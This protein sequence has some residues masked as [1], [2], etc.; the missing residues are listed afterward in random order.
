VIAADSVMRSSGLSDLR[1]F[2]FSLASDVDVDN[3]GYAGTV[4]LVHYC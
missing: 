4:T 1:S 2:G 3:N